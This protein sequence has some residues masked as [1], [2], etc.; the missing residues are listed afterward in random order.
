MM[1]SKIIL[2]LSILLI[3]TKSHGLGAWSE[4]TVGS[5][6]WGDVGSTGVLNDFSPAPDGAYVVTDAA[7]KITFGH[8]AASVSKVT[9]SNQN[10]RVFFDV[11]SGKA[12]LINP[13]ENMVYDLTGNSATAGRNVGSGFQNSTLLSDPYAFDGA[14]RTLGQR[15]SLLDLTP[16]PGQISYINDIPEFT[17]P[18]TADQGYRTGF[19][20][21]ANGC[22]VTTESPVL[23][24]ADAFAGID[25]AGRQVY[26]IG[27]SKYP[28]YLGAAVVDADKC[29]VDSLDLEKPN[30]EKINSCLTIRPQNSDV[31][32][33][34]Q[35]VDMTL[36]FITW[37]K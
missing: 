17:Y 2:G 10:S 9:P 6:A 4:S 19:Y 35:P 33:Q 26:Q 37:K 31:L 5:I 36:N 22:S 3:S 16:S 1:K 34:C 13:N 15:K 29:T 30:Y 32:L 28:D 24:M 7:Y 8:S 23:G 11:I 12:Y 27:L 14:L 20:F 18:Y 25:S 21:S